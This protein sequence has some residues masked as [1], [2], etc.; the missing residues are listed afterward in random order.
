M[1]ETYRVGIGY[2]IHRLVVDRK[3]LLA[4]VR[5]P[6]TKGLLGHSDSDVLAHAVCDALLGAAAL[7]DIGTHFPDSDPRWRGASSLDFLRHAVKL[8][9]AKG[10]RVVNVDAT[11]IA[12]QPKLKPYIPAMRQQ[13]ATVLNVAADCI[14]VK[15]KTNEG[16]DAIGRG[17][18][19]AAHAVALLTT[20]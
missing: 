13:L 1:S 16:L 11:V 18:A 7:G 17:D 20:R 2:D 8:I 6:F 9:T 5:V 14:S 3:L 19:M 15:A 10:Y 12:E 4:G